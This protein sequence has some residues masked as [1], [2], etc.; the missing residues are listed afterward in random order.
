MEKKTETAH[1]GEGPGMSGY[2]EVRGYFND[3]SNVISGWQDGE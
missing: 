2:E 3:G 1:V